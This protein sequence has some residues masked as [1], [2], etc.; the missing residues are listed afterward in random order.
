MKTHDYRKRY[1]GHDYTFEPTDKGLKASLMGWGSGIVAGDILLLENKKN[2]S[3]Y[4]VKEIKYFSDPKDM[5]SV[6]AE[7]VQLTEENFKDFSK[8][9]QK[10][11]E[12]V[13]GA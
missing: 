1:W 10:E 3:L 4:R 5:W 7:F 9:E 6:K 12:R 2:G 13:F 11:F 8:E